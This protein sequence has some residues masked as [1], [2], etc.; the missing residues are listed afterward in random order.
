MKKILLMPSWASLLVVCLGAIGVGLITELQKQN[1]F[2]PG[3]I[4]TTSATST[5]KVLYLAVKPGQ[6]VPHQA[7]PV[8]DRS[9]IQQ[10]SEA[11]SANNLAKYDQLVVS[12]KVRLVQ[13]GAAVEIIQTEGNLT[14]VKVLTRDIKGNDL[15]SQNWWVGSTFIQ[16]MSF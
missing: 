6:P 1:S 5:S 7:I 14:E 10:L 11:A 13:G 12:S 15:T 2:T 4:Q 9:T 8:A 16:E 3:A